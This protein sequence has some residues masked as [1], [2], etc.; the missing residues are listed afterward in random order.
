MGSE[1]GTVVGRSEATPGRVFLSPVVHVKAEVPGSLCNAHGCFSGTKSKAP[2]STE[3]SA[4]L[5][6]RVK[7]QEVPAPACCPWEP[8]K[9]PNASALGS[10]ADSLAAMGGSWIGATDLGFTST[11]TAQPDA[12][13]PLGPRRPQ[14]VKIQGLVTSWVRW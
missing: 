1:A 10:S 13:R 8:G 7:W 11:P 9:C 3:N 2:G 6:S 4:S 12:V 14:R 5:T